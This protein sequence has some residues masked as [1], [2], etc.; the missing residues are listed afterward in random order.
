MSIRF[1]AGVSLPRENVL[2]VPSRNVLLTG[3]RWRGG[4]TRSSD[5]DPG[6]TG[7]ASGAEESAEEADHAEAGCGGVGGDRAARAALIGEAG[8]ARGQGGDSRAAGPGV[9]P[10]AERGGPG[11]GG[12]SAVAGGLP[13]LWAEA[14]KRGSGQQTQAADRPQGAA[15]DHDGGWSVARE[16]AGVGAGTAVAPAA[17]LPWGTGARRYPAEPRPS[18]RFGHP[19]GR[20]PSRTHS[21]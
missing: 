12:S 3:R 7:S 1:R 14:G 18:L 15:A 5:D 8:G 4:S 13:G 2:L 20:A 19:L 17:E 16:A 10:E 6:R 21:P 11:P 9:E